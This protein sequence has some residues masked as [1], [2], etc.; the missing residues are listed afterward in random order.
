MSNAI[1]SPSTLHKRAAADHEL[2]AL[3][4]R[5]AAEYH[6]KSM[7]HAARAQRE[8]AKECSI[9]AHRSVVAR[10]ASNPP[11]RLPRRAAAWRGPA[12]RRI[13]DARFSMAALEQ[14]MNSDLV[15]WSSERN[16]MGRGIHR[17]AVRESRRLEDATDAELQAELAAITSQP[18]AGAV[19]PRFQDYPRRVEAFQTD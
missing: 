13:V 18:V 17:E 8:D 7:L 11:I 6:D 19:A 4:H 9:K 14:S 1:R 5:T 10:R 16:D 15:W 12:I 3:Q 2:A